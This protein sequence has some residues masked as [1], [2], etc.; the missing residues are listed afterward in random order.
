MSITS[1]WQVSES[2][3]L[4]VQTTGSLDT[5]GQLEDSAGT[6]LASNDDGG[7]GYN[8][9]IVHAVSAGTYYIKVEGYDASTIGSYTIHASGPG[10][11]SSP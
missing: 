10:G 5:K 8:F 1:A 7:D 9:R 6:V 11:G 4:T 2:G 3:E